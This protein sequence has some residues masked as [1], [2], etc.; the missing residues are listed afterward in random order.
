MD[1]KV[2]ILIRTSRYGKTDI[3]TREIDRYGRIWIGTRAE[4]MSRIR[5]LQAKRHLLAH[6]EYGTPK[7]T[8]T[9]NLKN[10]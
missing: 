2:N 8:I 7:Y 1:K 4:A 6:N 9:Y 10:N 3:I 5:V